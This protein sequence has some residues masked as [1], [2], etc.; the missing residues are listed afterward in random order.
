MEEYDHSLQKELKKFRILYDLAIAMTAERNLE[1][2]LQLVVEKSRELLDTDTSYIALRD[3]AR[4]DVYMHSLSGIRTEPF[5]NLRLPFGEGLGGL[6]A[7]SRQGIIVEDYLGEKVITHVVDSIV[8]EEGVVS[9]VAVPV[10]IGQTSLGVLYA[11]NRRRTSFTQADLEGLHLIGNLAAVEISRKRAEDFV[12]HSRVDLEQKVAARTSEL[13]RANQQL[14]QE[15]QQRK[16]AEERIR[17][18]ERRYRSIFENAVEGMFQSTVAGSFIA[19]NPALAKMY[20]YGSPE[21]L[22][23]GLK[24]INTQLYVDPGR[25]NQLIH[26]LRQWGEVRDF[27]AEAYR[28]DGSVAITSI[29]ARQVR[30]ENGEV[31]CIEGSVKDI[32]EQKAAEK[33]IRESE[34]RYRDL[35][36]NVS[37]FIYFHDMEGNITETNLA[38]RKASGY[39]LHPHAAMRIKDMMPEENRPLFD[40]YIRRITERGE[41]EGFMKVFSREGREILIEYKNTL[42]RDPNGDVLGVRGSARD[43]TDRVRAEKEKK[44]LQAQIMSA[45]RI[46]AIGTLAGGIAHNFNN[47]LMA[48]QGNATLARLEVDPA[49][50]VSRK[51]ENI[52][53]L[54]KSGA[55]L[56]SQLLGYARGGRYEVKTINLND[57]VKDVSN[58][59][60]QARKDITVRLDLSES[61]KGIEADQGQLEQVILNLLVNAADA[62]PTGGKVVLRTRN[63][64]HG[65]MKGKPYKPKKGK[66]VLLEVQDSGIGMDRRTMDRIFEPFFTTKGMGKGTGLGLA[67]T[68]GIVKGHGGYIDVASREQKGSTFQIYLPASEKTVV[69]KNEFSKGVTMG[70]GTILLVDDEEMILEVGKGMLETLGYVVLASGGGREAVE[71]YT[72]N[73]DSIDLVVLDLVMPGMGGRETYQQLKAVDPGIRVLLSSGFSIDALAKEMLE[74]G[75]DGFIQKPF[76][77]QELSQ[78]V[79]RVLSNRATDS[80][81]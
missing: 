42:V 69:E 52:E 8:A 35:F 67:S 39:D 56:T 45:Q 75:C 46:E 5:R 74:Q 63:L 37:D 30:D 29:S 79:A 33:A 60:A 17:E 44:R 40:E 25:R 12:R 38:F 24:D 49:G 28:K 6:V 11:F 66:Y 59:F 1:E 48:I 54:V 47:L 3:E 20:G 41:D 23:A 27:E 65:E 50:P 16:R 76:F 73:H 18:S 80:R 57:L 77:I 78:E 64:S 51:L 71:I 2:N 81:Q 22:M 55:K 4:G 72:R 68:Y 32:T 7:E 31:L 34:K 13:W 9:G 26:L 21:E 15:I 10:Q 62:M 19:V 70:K 36:E 43:V 14:E 61:L 58:T 53:K